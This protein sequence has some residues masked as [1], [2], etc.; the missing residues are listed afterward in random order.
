MDES[1][2]ERE[3]RARLRGR[4][5]GRSSSAR[6]VRRAEISI[7]SLPRAARRR[8]L[9]DRLVG[10]AKVCRLRRASGEMADRSSGASLSAPGETI[11]GPLRKEPAAVSSQEEVSCLNNSRQAGLE[12]TRSLLAD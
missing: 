11:D 1:I 4:A 8:V 2:L 9:V 6:L 7:S 5:R 10:V 12:R 3:T